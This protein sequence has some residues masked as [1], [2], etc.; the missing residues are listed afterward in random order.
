MLL[1]DRLRRHDLS[2]KKG[3]RSEDSD[4]AAA[5]PS[6]KGAPRPQRILVYVSAVVRYGS[7]RKAA[8]S[9]HMSSSALNRRILDL[10]DEIGTALFERLPRGVRLTSAG[11]LYINYARRVLAET[12]LVG[13]QIERLRG[14]VRG[15]VKIAATESV[16][17]HLL[18]EAVSRFQDDHPGVYFEITIVPAGLL[19][20]KLKSDAVD[21]ILTHEQINRNEGTVLASIA[22]RYCAMVSQSHPLADRSSLRL[23]DCLAYPLALADETMA[24]R[25]LLNQV[26]HKAS[27]QLEPM[28]VSNSIEVM[29]AFAKR[30]N[31]ICF[32]FEVGVLGDDHDMVAIPLV[33][34]PLKQAKL[35][36]FMRRGRALPVAVAVFSEQLVTTLQALS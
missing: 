22:Q 9:L 26:L 28:L 4:S 8:E 36:L 2:D 11:E 20:E 31:G 16:A 35:H 27:F 34:P 14:L 1:S 24:G 29:R 3:A 21:L 10:E 15:R 25:E 12:E 23:Q 32:Q 5:L 19:L 7:I 30:N 13:S 6:H 18:P 33:D 17:G